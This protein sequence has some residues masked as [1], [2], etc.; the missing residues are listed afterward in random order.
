LH[1][2]DE[3]RAAPDSVNRMRKLV[4]DGAIS[5]HIGQVTGL[6]GNAGT[7]SAV[8]CKGA[9]GAFEIACDTLLPFFGLTMKL[10][11]WPS[12][13]WSCTRT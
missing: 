3:F 10:G 9:E 1:R 8:E 5:L 13:G 7:L 2:R 6:R 11:R 12:G 4:E